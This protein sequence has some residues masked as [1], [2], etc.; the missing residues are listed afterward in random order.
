MFPMHALPLVED[1]DSLQDTLPPVLPGFFIPRL[2]DKPQNP[3]LDT[4]K[5][6]HDDNA[7]TRTQ[8]LEPPEIAI[9][10]ADFSA[11]RLV[12][13]PLE[14]DDSLWINALV[15]VTGV[16][17]RILSW[18]NLRSFQSKRA[19]QTGFL[20]EQGSGTFASVR[21]HVQPR[22]R[23][24]DTEVLHVTADV[25]WRNLKMT[26]CGISSQLHVWNLI[27]EQFVQLGVRNGRNGVII[28][29]GKDES[30]SDSICASFLRIGTLLRRLEIFIVTL[31]SRSPTEGPT[32]HAFAHTMSNVLSFLR[33]SLAEHPLTQELIAK[34]ALST[35]LAFYAYYEDIM[36]VLARLCGRDE[37]I[38][39]TDYIVL[40]S[41]P[42]VLLSQIYD[43]LNIHIERRS[44]KDIIAILAYILTSTSP[45]YLLQVSRSVG[46]GKH[47]PL[48]QTSRV[49]G[50]RS[51][52]YTSRL[53]DDTDTAKQLNGLESE[54][55]DVFPGFFAELSDA[56][57]AARKSLV[58]LMA[59]RPDHPMLKAH[60]A[61]DIRWFWSPS[62]ID[63]A[64][65][66]RPVRPSSNNTDVHRQDDNERSFSRPP[67][68]SQ[69]DVFD[70][71]PGARSSQLCLDH[72][73]IASTTKLKAYIHSFP[74]TLPLIAPTLP[75][76]TSL[77]LRP[78]LVHAS[79]LS[80]ELLSF[81]LQP[82]TPLNIRTHMKLLQSYLLL[83]SPQFKSRLAAALFS[84]NENYDAQARNPMSLQALRIRRRNRSSRV[85]MQN[86]AWAVGLAP[87]LLDREM[88][89]PVGADLSFFL[90]TVIVDSFESGLLEEVDNRLG[91]AIRDLPTGR[92]RDRWLNPLCASLDFLYMEYK[93]PRP[94][95]VL[96]TPEI[97]AKYQRMFTF[98]L[99]LMRVEHAITAVFRMTRSLDAPLFPTLSAPRKKLLHLRFISH[100]LVSTL[101]QYIC[102]TAI[103]GNFDT[104]L[105]RLSPHA[106]PFLHN[107][108]PSGF[109]DVFALARAHSVLL[110]DILSA[111]LMRSSQRQAGDLLRDSLELILEFSILAGQLRRKSLE[112]YQA[113]PLL[114]DLYTRLRKKM[115]NFTSVVKSMVDSNISTTMQ[116]AHPEGDRYLRKPPGGTQAL[117][118]LLLRL[119]TARDWW[120]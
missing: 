108:E 18:D 29:D 58:L 95:Q 28:V 12:S 41:R 69:F 13:E 83:G 100:S 11:L 67:E 105:E 17:T 2:A 101:C 106:P 117:A 119:D 98:L 22:L 6:E 79:K 109:S 74:E 115:L 70:L 47:R 85:D 54:S 68:F 78:L 96:I 112:E 80:G 111:C 75:H 8:N 42:Q 45:E 97:L 33:E 56:L 63:D 46:F 91:F 93:P 49:I 37:D 77:V 35:K 82:S 36:V 1:E 99:R 19:A 7:S 21:Y 113:A 32:I 43:H 76:L 20:S 65:N 44:H 71:E 90:R 57:P 24:P 14:D 64:F 52:E 62:E 66:D 102:D 116:T 107:G 72:I 73:S 26:I 25:L 9:M 48:P 16:T 3:I 94:L 88:W 84:D 86:S 5:R 55:S 51:D 39:P 40:E 23:D 60:S 15:Q 27:S 30:I 110:D 114:D 81:F 10:A 53:F 103:G 38:D 104:F 59:A 34:G 120:A 118:T 61:E 92:G 31:R 4:L 87:S 50:D 89:P